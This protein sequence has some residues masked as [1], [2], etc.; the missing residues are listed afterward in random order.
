MKTDLTEKQRLIYNY[1]KDTIRTK[2]YP[3]SVREIC[4][5]TGLKST[6]TVHVHLENLEKKG[7]I[8]RESFKNRSIEILEDSFYNFAEET[9]SIPIIGRVAAGAPVLAIENIEDYFPVPASYLRGHTDVFMLRIS[10][11]SMIEAGIHD[12][13]LVF[14]QK[15][16]Y[17]YDGD[18]VI[19]LI[20][21]SATCKRFFSN[22]SHVVLK[23]ENSAYQPIVSDHVDVLGKVIGLFRMYTH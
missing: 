7:Y 14:V 19:A 18:I 11:D 10:G 8:H 17:A 9:V 3:P 12:K 16:S 20:D 13:D 6:S 1:L 5:A 4:S 2:G 21:E 22:G 23:S 15:Q